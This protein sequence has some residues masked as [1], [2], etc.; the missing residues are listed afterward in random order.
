MD[1]EKC[2]LE[3]VIEDFKKEHELM[4]REY[5]E[6]ISAMQVVQQDKDILESTTTDLM[7]R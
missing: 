4:K 2:R 3:K 5:E 1:E 6:T 7:V